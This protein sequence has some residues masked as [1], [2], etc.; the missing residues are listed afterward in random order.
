MEEALWPRMHIK[1]PQTCIIHSVY[2]SMPAK[3]ASL[4]KTVLTVGSAE[5]PNSTEP[6][7]AGL[8]LHGEGQ[9]KGHHSSEL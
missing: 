9:G 3:W 8:A 2:F 4:K 6:C 1:S 7:R 5:T